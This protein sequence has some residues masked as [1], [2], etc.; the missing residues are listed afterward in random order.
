MISSISPQL[1][2]SL[3]DS[4]VSSGRY[5][6]VIFDN[7]VTPIDMVIAILMESTG[8]DESEAFIECWEAQT[9]GK[10][11]VHFSSQKECQEIAN[12]ISSIGVATEVR[13]EWD[14]VD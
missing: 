9:F 1:N 4:A 2:P 14:D 12:I 6:V 7:D 10:T 13:K 11:S 8:C 5:M 3:S